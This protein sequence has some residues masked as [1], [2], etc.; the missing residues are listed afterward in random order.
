M[1]QP[2]AQSVVAG[3]ELCGRLELDAERLTCYDLLHAVYSSV[4]A[5]TEPEAQTRSELQPEPPPEPDT[6]IPEPEPASI[7]EAPA[8]VDTG[9]ID[10]SSADADR[11]GLRTRPEEADGT[12]VVVVEVRRNISGLAIFVTE[13]GQVWLQTSS[14][15]RRY[16]EIPFTARIEPGSVGSY[17]LTPVGG[18]TAVR[19]QRRQ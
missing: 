12:T 10:L 15:S 4:E 13:N 14:R 6:P 19:V 18:G 8:A 9:S 17:F 1:T 16:S 2:R 3:L 11:F 7:S 5:E